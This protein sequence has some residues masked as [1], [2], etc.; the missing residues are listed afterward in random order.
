MRPGRGWTTQPA[1]TG[2]PS[3]GPRSAPSERW[4][5][6]RGGR[7]GRSRHVRDPRRDLGPAG[8]AELGQDV[9]DVRAGGLRRDLQLT[10]DLGV[11]HA[12]GDQPGDFELAGG[13]RPP[14]LLERCPARARSWRARRRAPSAG[15][16]PSASAVERTDAINRRRF[17]VAV[18]AQQ[19]LREVQAGPRRFPDPTT[20]RPSRCAA[21]SRASRAITI[22]PAARRSR[23]S[24]CASAGPATASQPARWSRDSRPPAL[25]LLGPAGGQERPGPGDDERDQQRP[26]AGRQ[27]ELQALL[28]ASDGIAR[29]DRPAGRLRPGPRA[30]SG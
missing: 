12:L 14:R 3:L 7:V 4:L 13:Q 29:V 20:L 8:H 16:L 5:L 19:A 11:G 30:A 15:S 1:E 22:D 17:A 23:P 18:R 6:G 27:R 21:A 28:A 26:L 2:P 9:L 25:R 24:A 10:G